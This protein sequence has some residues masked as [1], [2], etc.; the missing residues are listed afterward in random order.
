M[1]SYM[2]KCHCLNVLR[3]IS[4]V[5]EGRGKGCKK[6]KQKNSFRIA[7]NSRSSNK[8]FV[9]SVYKEKKIL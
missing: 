8:V 6:V 4:E 9:S 7:N 2:F 1:N 3:S 5:N